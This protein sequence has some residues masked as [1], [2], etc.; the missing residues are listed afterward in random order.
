MEV[1]LKSAISSLI[2]PN[3]TVDTKK[4]L[5]KKELEINGRIKR[6]DDRQNNTVQEENKSR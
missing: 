1:L 5:T 2:F 3:S 6:A 4:L